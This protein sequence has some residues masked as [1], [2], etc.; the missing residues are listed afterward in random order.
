MRMSQTGQISDSTKRNLF[1]LMSNYKMRMNEPQPFPKEVPTLH[2]KIVHAAIT[3]AGMDMQ[4]GAEAINFPEDIFRQLYGA[5]LEKDSAMPS[6]HL[7][8]V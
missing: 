8:L 1:V 4:I 6:Q 2:K 3:D 7:R 5:F